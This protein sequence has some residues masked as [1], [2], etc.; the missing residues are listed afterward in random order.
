ME[1]Y[2]VNRDRL[3]VYL[4]DREL[5]ARH[6]DIH[7]LFEDG[8]AF[9]E[10]LKSMLESVGESA[11]FPIKNTPLEVELFPIADGDLLISLCRNAVSEVQ[12]VFSDAEDLIACCVALSDCFEGDSKLY[13]YEGKYYL[14]LKTCRESACT[15]LLAEFADKVCAPFAVSEAVLSEYGQ[16]ICMQN[17]VDLFTKQFGK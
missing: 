16:S 1:I 15:C 12:A 13:L 11:H 14:C 2:F 4:T 6:I 7:K 9:Q 17:C 10:E 5:S 3:N 8:K